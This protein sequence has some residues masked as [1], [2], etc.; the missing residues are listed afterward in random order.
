MNCWRLTGTTLRVCFIQ[1]P[2]PSSNMAEMSS[3]LLSGEG[4][5]LLDVSAVCVCVC[6][7][8]GSKYRSLASFHDAS[9]SSPAGNFQ[10]HKS[11]PLPSPPAG[12]YAPADLVSPTTSATKDRYAQDYMN[13]LNKR[14][15]PGDQFRSSVSP[16]P[17]Q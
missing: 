9:L 8:C 16:P 6:V 14:R 1:M 2:S 17:N 15:S 13:S 10:E 12:S 5:P 4:S 7:V 3:N 11:P